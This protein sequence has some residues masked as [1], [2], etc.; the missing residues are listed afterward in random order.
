[1]CILLPWKQF[2]PGIGLYS[3]DSGP[4]AKEPCWGWGLRWARKQLWCTCSRWDSRTHM[5]S[6]P[7]EPVSFVQWEGLF[8]PARR[9]QWHLGFIA[10]ISPPRI[11]CFP[12]HIPQRWLGMY[13]PPRSAFAFLVS[14]P[15]S[16]SGLHLGPLP[17]FIWH[18]EAWSPQ[19]ATETSNFWSMLRVGN[20][21]PCT[22]PCFAT[23]REPSEA[24]HTHDSTH[25][26]HIEESP[27]WPTLTR[28]WPLPPSTSLS[29]W[30]NLSKV[31]VTAC[32][33]SLLSC[34][35]LPFIKSSY[36]FRRGEQS[37]CFV[38]TLLAVPIA[39]DWV[40]N[41]ESPRKMLMCV[42]FIWE[43]SAQGRKGMDR[44][45]VWE[46]ARDTVFPCVTG[47]DTTLLRAR[48]R[49]CGFVAAVFWMWNFKLS[50]GGRHVHTA[51][52]VHGGRRRA[53]GCSCFPSSFLSACSRMTL[54]AHSSRVL[55]CRFWALRDS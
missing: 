42:Q 41:K 4:G 33:R 17:T 28:T 34:W 23:S 54:G 32:Q 21:L 14:Q 37:C 1:M 26:L 39:L 2:L 38:E 7:R 30:W 47:Q 44:R 22:S 52:H 45:K 8:L 24:R 11:S 13:E 36:G 31:D 27:H 43:C 40:L 25:C 19:V 6:K 46:E 35:L 29:P 50:K 55:G 10:K 5:V 15:P 16:Q 49:P 51:Q 12:F 9:A 3:S 53:G 20:R 48:K 18:S